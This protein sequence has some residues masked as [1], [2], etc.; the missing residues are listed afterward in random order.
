MARPPDLTGQFVVRRHAPAR[1]LVLLGGALL[2]A[3]LALYAA[4]ELGRRHAGFDQLA[5]LAE[6]SRYGQRLRELQQQ[7]RDLRTQVAAFDTFR[8][9]D[10][11]EHA[12]VRREMAE[13]RAR[14]DRDQQDLAV[15][16]G[17]VTPGRA[18]QWATV[19][20]LRVSAGAA[21]Q[22]FHLHL[23]VVQPGRAQ[24]TLNG[25]LSLTIAG[26]SGGRD[27]S[28]PLPV[29]T[30]GR[31]QDVSFSVRY[32]QAVDRDLQL[33]AGFVPSQLHV[34]LRSTRAADA[35]LDFSFPWSVEAP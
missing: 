21:A 26:S 22:Q 16:R 24:A 31:E 1:R 12:E 23:V 3:V 35:P 17:V 20:Q 15:Y 18:G 29:L 33:P 9:A 30:A 11:R 19:E 5:E 14:V 28:L 8:A 10:A 27:A 34:Q 2:L 7:N 13:L 4:F 6:R 25:T 32:F